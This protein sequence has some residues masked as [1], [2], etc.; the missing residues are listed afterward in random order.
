MP[1][2][3]S[4]QNP[5]KVLFY[6]G[7]VEHKAAETIQ[8]LNLHKILLIGETRTLYQPIIQDLRSKLSIVIGEFCNV[9]VFKRLGVLLLILRMCRL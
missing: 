6:S 2:A 7:C 3:F 4:T 1:K 9:S 8:A 5:S